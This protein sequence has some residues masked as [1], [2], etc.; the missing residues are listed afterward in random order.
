MVRNQ[1]VVAVFCLIGFAGPL[2]AQDDK[3]H[4]ILAFDE[5]GKLDDAK[6][7]IEIKKDLIRRKPANVFLIAHGWRNSMERADETFTYFGK[8]LPALEGKDG[9]TAVIGI[10]WPSLLGEDD[11]LLDLAFTRVAK[12]IANVIA[13]SKNIDERKE[14]LKTF[15]KKKT[16]R[17]LVN[18]LLKFQL[19]DDEHLDLMIEHFDEPENVEKLLTMFTYWQMKKRAGIVGSTG[20]PSCLTELQDALPHSRLHL[21]GHSFGCKVVLSGLAS[22]V[23]AKHKVDSVT[24]LQGAV[25]TLCFAPKIDELKGL[26]GAYAKIPDRVKGCIAVTFTK[27]D[28]ALGKFYLAASQSGGHVG[29]LPD[30]NHKLS[31]GLY[32][33]L[34]A[35]GIGRVDGLK[36]I[37]MG[38]MGAVY[39]L[40]PGLNSLDADKIIKNHG[41]IRTDAVTWLIWSVAR[42]QP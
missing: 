35:K 40:R 18:E 28:K 31:P 12:T 4:L 27:N 5:H 42:A 3:N 26:P 24:L 41:D 8:S 30:R 10:R 17:I 21:V 34:G 6:A 16:T 29:E 7:W 39:Q 9:P 37:E 15:L 36:P 14:K 20:F 13:K 33:A 23:R 1:F 11:T 19:P 32:G 38:K 25:S 22:E 2:V